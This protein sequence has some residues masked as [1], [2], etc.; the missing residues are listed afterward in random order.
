MSTSKLVDDF[1]VNTDNMFRLP[2]WVGGRYSVDSAIGLSLMTVIG[3]TPSPLARIPSSTAISRRS[4]ESN[5]PVLLGLIGLWYSNFFGAQSRRGARY[6]M[7]CRVFRPTF[8]S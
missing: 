8:S 6:S 1:G 3:A 2:D 5:A 7:A 4:A